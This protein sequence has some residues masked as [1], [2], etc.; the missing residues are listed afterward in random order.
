[1]H[2]RSILIVTLPLPLAIESTSDTTFTLTGTG[3]S[4]QLVPPVDG[5]K[6]G[7][8]ISAEGDIYLVIDTAC[9]I[10]LGAAADGATVTQGPTAV[11]QQVGCHPDAL[12]YRHV[13]W[14]LH[15]RHGLAWRE[16]RAVPA[17]RQSTYLGLEHRQ[18]P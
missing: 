15:R 3:L 4:A 18:N 14:V 10:S 12:L 16:R 6:S 17:R 11:P 5:V 9:S 1:M 13:E 2:F 8:S 7:N